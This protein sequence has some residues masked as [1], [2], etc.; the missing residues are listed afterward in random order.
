[1]SFHGVSIPPETIGESTFSEKLRGVLITDLENFAR[2]SAFQTESGQGT[3]ERLKDFISS[4]RPVIVLVDLGFWLVTKPHYIVVFGYTEEGFV[5][6]DGEHA[7]QLYP[8]DQFK[9]IWAKMG[10]PY[11]LVYR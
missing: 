6:H 3:V 5:A 9:E 1:M 2:R 8:Y 10:R 7:S 4:K 11:L